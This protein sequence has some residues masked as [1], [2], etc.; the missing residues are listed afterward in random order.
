MAEGFARALG[1]GKIE[2]FSAGSRPSGDVNPSAIEVMREAGVD[3]SKQFSKGV[4]QL[5]QE[6]YEVIVTMGCGDACPQIPAYR[7]LDWQIP[8][9]VGQDRA[10]FVQVRE[11]VRQK[12]SELLKETNP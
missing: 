10:T 1:G 5:P 4:G 12:I 7:R 2:V 8:D 9:P 3:I 11:L 6:K